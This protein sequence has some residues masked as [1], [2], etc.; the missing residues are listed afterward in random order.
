[1]G[2]A[3]NVPSEQ[4]IVSGPD[5]VNLSEQLTVYCVPDSIVSVTGV[6]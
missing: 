3:D 6:T 1:M 2:R 4:V 5:I